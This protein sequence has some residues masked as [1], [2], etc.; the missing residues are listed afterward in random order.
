M[1]IVTEFRCDECG[2][3]NTTLTNA[4]LVDVI[5]AFTC[6]PDEL[7]A[8]R[9]SPDVWSPREY[10]WHMASVVDFYG[11][12]I[13]QVISTERPQLHG[14]DYTLDPTPAPA[15]DVAAVVVR[16]RALT[17]EQWQRVGLGSSD[18]AERDI[19][20]LASRLAHECHHHALDMTRS[21]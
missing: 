11:G 2:F 19:R 9:P 17:P 14:V 12:R 13:E 3:D 5:A 18:A 10:A 6:N 1:E 15:P 21:P 4:E 20:N 8:A 16:L 7:S